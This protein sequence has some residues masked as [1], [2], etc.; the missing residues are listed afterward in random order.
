MRTEGGPALPGSCDTYGSFLES[1][2]A[3]GAN[4]PQRVLSL[5]TALSMLGN[6]ERLGL[7]PVD[8]PIALAIVAASDHNRALTSSGFPLLDTLE[9]TERFH[10]LYIEAD[11]EDDVLRAMEEIYALTGRR[12]HT[13]ILGG[14]G[15]PTSLALGGEDLALGTSE[16]VYDE[17]NYLDTSDFYRGEFSA[18]NEFMETDGQVLLL[19]CSTGSGGVDSPFNMA[20][21]VSRAVPGR[22]VYSMMEPGNLRKLEVAEDGSLQVEWNNDAPYVALSTDGRPPELPARVG[23]QNASNG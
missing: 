17:R 19:S 15:T 22:R 10:L 3:L 21:S 6:H 13:L 1:L 4:F 18:M 20:N 8:R 9:E 2:A 7:E 16:G 11:D 12:I 5:R 23:A 14:H